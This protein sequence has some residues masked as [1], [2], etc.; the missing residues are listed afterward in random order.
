MFPPGLLDLQ[1]YL[2]HGTAM[3]L[4]EKEGNQKTKQMFEGRRIGGVL[5]S[6]F[7]DI[8][9]RCGYGFDTWR[10]NN[11]RNVWGWNLVARE[12]ESEE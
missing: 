10:R 7:S 8:K 3:M 6:Q 1:F 4:K 9:G 11:L 2:D 5:H 12:K